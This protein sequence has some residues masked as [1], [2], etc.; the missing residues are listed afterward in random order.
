MQYKTPNTI[1]PAEGFLGFQSKCK[2]NSSLNEI[3]LLFVWKRKQAGAE[4]GQAQL[5]LKLETWSYLI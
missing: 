2:V 1:L 4:L 3:I 5:K